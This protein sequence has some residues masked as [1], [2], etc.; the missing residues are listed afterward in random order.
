L[1]DFAIIIYTEMLFIAKA[2]FTNHPDTLKS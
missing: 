1:K 2:F